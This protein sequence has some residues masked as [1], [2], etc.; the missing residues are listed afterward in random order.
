[1]NRS[2]EIPFSNKRHAEIAYD[3]LRIDP[4]PKRSFVTKT[5]TVEDNKLKV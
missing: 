2:I 1:M 5:I 4:E 3:V